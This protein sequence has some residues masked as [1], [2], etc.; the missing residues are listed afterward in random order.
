MFLMLV[1]W[2]SKTLQKSFI[3]EK[4]FFFKYTFNK[5]VSYSDDTT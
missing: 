4:L 5:Y 1:E 2:A 3:Y